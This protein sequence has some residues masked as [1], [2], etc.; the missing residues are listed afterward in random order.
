LASISIVIVAYNSGEFLRRCLAAVG[1]GHGEVVV[2]D[3]GSAES[4]P[5]VAREAVR[6]IKRS[7][8]DG[9]GTAANAGVANTSGR[10]VLLLN[11]DAWPLEDGVERL[12]EFAESRPGLG[13]AGPCLFDP[14]GQPQRSTIRPPLGAARLAAWG[15]FPRAVTSLYGA[16]RRVTSVVPRKRVRPTEFLQGSAL[17]VRRDAFEQV[18]GFDESFFMYGEDAD[19]CARLRGAGW[20]VELCPAARF[21]HVGGGS[22]GSEAQRMELELLR[23]WLRLIAKHDGIREAERARRWTSRALRARA[24]A[25]PRRRPVARWLGSGHARELLGLPE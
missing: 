17:L 15:A 25:S 3:N 6:L 21:V 16:W 19:L 12:V 7:R 10:W 4:E 22:T 2:V 8:N 1:S 18:G 9:F 13:A 11:P 20:E 14:D 23:S 5:H 24:L